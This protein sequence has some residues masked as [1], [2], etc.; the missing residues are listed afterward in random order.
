MRLVL[1]LL[2]ATLVALG[3][4][5]RPRLVIAY[6]DSPSP[7]YV[8]PDGTGLDLVLVREACTTLNIELRLECL[9][10]KRCLVMLEA[11][12]LDGLSSA[13]FTAE[14]NAFARYPELDDGTLD[15]QRQ[16]HTDTY[17]LYR[18]IGSSLHWDGQRLHGLQGPIG[19]QS[20]F[21]VIAQLTALGATVDDSSKHLAPIIERMLAGRVV[22]AAFMVTAAEAHL[23]ANPGLSTTIE[24]LDPPLIEKP[25]FLIFSRQTYV[26]QAALCES[27]WHTMAVIRGSEEHRKRMREAGLLVP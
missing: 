6:E 15:A 22:G 4:E 23:R 19:A 3:A 12:K 7:P 24:R 21:S 1:G 13:S 5:D 25:Y 10:W 26:N 2:W 9:P 20:G 14:R 27:V 8:N 18:P 11:G 16:L 17:A